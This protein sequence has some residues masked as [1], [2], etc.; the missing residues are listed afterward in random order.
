MSERMCAHV[1]S[2]AR[3][4]HQSSQGRM[5]SY[6][7]RKGFKWGSTSEHL[8]SIQSTLGSISHSIFLSYFITFVGGWG[9]REHGCVSMWAI[10]S[11]GNSQASIFFL[12]LVRLVK[13]IYPLSYLAS[14][15]QETFITEKYRL[16]RSYPQEPWEG[17][18]AIKSGRCLRR[19]RRQ[20][21]SGF[22][23]EGAKESN[24]EIWLACIVKGLS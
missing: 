19:R 17:K 4:T 10:G 20:K 3:Q 16:T 1:R 5:T 8:P 22:Y 24:E 11:E 23:L 6:D 14:P 7:S 18:E 13:L 15:F 21:Q 12:P 2:H 9:A